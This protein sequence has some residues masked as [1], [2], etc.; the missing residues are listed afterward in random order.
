M[1]D[2]QSRWTAGSAVDEWND[3][4]ALDGSKPSRLNPVKGHPFRRRV[5][6]VGVEVEL[7][8]YVIGLG[9]A[10]LDSA[11]PLDGPGGTPRLWHDL[12]IIEY[13]SP[14]KP[15]VTSPAGQSS[16]Q[17]FTPTQAGH[18]TLRFSRPQGGAWWLHIDAQDPPP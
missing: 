6:T 11:L 18:H 3:P 10:P 14:T 4:E 1:P 16:V 13:P 8:A 2:F 12:E 17:R 15:A 5:A 7:S 9:V